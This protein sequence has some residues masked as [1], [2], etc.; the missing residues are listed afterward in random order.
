MLDFYQ[1]S[2]NRIYQIFLN[3]RG[4]LINNTIGFFAGFGLATMVGDSPHLREPIAAR[5]LAWI[6]LTSSGW[7]A[8]HDKIVGNIEGSSRPERFGL[9]TSPSFSI[10]FYLGLNFERYVQMK[11]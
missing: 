9:Y 5:D 6:I 8:W 10:G 3:E 2:K 4:V 11:S 7:I 1:N